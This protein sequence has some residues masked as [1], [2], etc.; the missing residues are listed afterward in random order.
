MHK[1]VCRSALISSSFLLLLLSCE[2]GLREK[3]AGEK[4]REDPVIAAVN[5]PLAYFAKRLADGFATVLFDIP[6][7]QDP[8]FWE[9]SDQQVT[10]IQKADLILLNGANYAK[11][12]A[13]RTLPYETTV[14]TSSSFENQLIRLKDSISHKHKKGS[15]SHSH[16]G[17]AFTTWLDLKQ[18]SAQAS[19]VALA[20]TE[21]FPRHKTTLMNRLQDLQ[22]DL[23]ALDIAMKAAAS[24]LR[25]A[26]VITSHPVYHYWSRA[27]D[28]VTPSL[29]WEPGNEITPQDMAALANIRKTHPDA[30]VFIWESTPLGRNVE[31]LK[32]AGLISIVIS[33]CANQPAEGDFLS[34]MRN[35]IAALEA[36]G[37]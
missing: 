3:P 29:L 35:N 8:A 37:N 7:G 20:L 21:Q 33:P 32:E 1:S 25:P 13:T 6:A 19:A 11:W 22:K 27:Y 18:A 34:V 10:S 23:K 17:L 5:Y 16:E 15:E 12:T 24:K 28:L 36:S 31:L 14:V 26:T 30:T 2:E 4:P 9:P